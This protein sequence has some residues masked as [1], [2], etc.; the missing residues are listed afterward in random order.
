MDQNVCSDKK[1]A[2]KINKFDVNIVLWTRN[3]I[4]TMIVYTKY[5]FATKKYGDEKQKIDTEFQVIT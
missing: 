3:E 1:K 5:A 4:I 2:K